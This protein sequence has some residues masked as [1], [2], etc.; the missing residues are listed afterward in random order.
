[1][2]PVA[3]RTINFKILHI[4]DKNNVDHPEFI[5]QEKVKISSAS[6][7]TG[8]DGT[9]KVKLIC[10]DDS[11]TTIPG[12]KIIDI[13][14]ELQPLDPNSATIP[15]S[16]RMGIYVRDALLLKNNFDNQTYGTRLSD[17]YK[18]PFRSWGFGT[19]HA[20]P[21]QHSCLEKSIIDRPGAADSMFS[22]RLYAETD[23]FEP[24]HK[25]ADWSNLMYINSYWPMNIEAKF[26]VKTGNEP[27]EHSQYVTKRERCYIQFGIDHGNPVMYFDENNQILDI[28]SEI[29]QGYSPG[30]WYNVTMQ[31]VCE[32]FTTKI[33]YFI[34]KKQVK[35]VDISGLYNGGGF[36]VATHGGTVWCDEI[37]IYNLTNLPKKSNPDFKR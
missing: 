22:A 32:N 28:N 37:E 25:Y 1:M 31:I 3:G 17:I 16:R 34:D 23:L 7:T 20:D 33:I 21:N 30:E 2:E 5:N 15:L 35:I 26:C 36:V 8:N 9:C 14:A 11:L 13:Q 6:N 18:S 24:D 10:T 19:P 27:L 4:L 12:D 29:L